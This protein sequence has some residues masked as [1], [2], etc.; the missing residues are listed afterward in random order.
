MR[1]SIQVIRPYLLG[2]VTV[3]LAFA[4][5]SFIQPHISTSPPFIL[6]LVAIMFVAWAWG[7]RPAVWVTL[8]SAIL[9]DY[10][11]I[12]PLQS[13]SLSVA[14]FGSLLFFCVVA[15]TMAYTIERLRTGQREAITLGRQL[16][17][18]HQLSTQLFQEKNVEQTLDSIL[19][20]AIDLLDAD[21]GLLQLYDAPGKTLLLTAQTGFS[22]EFCR[23]FERVSLDFSSCGA[24]FQRRQ[25][26]MIENL[27]TD[28]ELS[29]IASLFS[30]DHVSSAQSTPL[31]RADGHVLGVLTTYSPHLPSE[32]P[33]HLFDLFAQQAARILEAKLSQETL[34][35]NKHALEQQLSIT[36]QRL[37]RTISE[38][39]ISEEQERR[40]LASEL[41]DYLAQM[42]ALGNLKLQLAQRALESS[43]A[44]AQR[45]MKET[46][47]A[48][49]R[50]MVYTRTVM[51]EL[52]PPE[53]RSSGLPAALV[54]LARQMPK[55]GLTVS[56]HMNVESVDLPH[57]QA[58][59]LYKSARELL[60]NVIKHA[61]TDQVTLSLSIDPDET[62]VLSV[63]DH[64]R[65]YDPSAAKPS[66]GGRNFGLASIRERMNVIGG[67]L[68]EDSTIGSGT[69]I[70]LGLPL[71]EAELQRPLRAAS[72]SS[73][74]DRVKSKPV[75]SSE[76]ERLPYENPFG[77]SSQ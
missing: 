51:A 11:L 58:V 26:V 41:H 65:G 37:R 76:Q 13:L 49:Q 69:T 27:A 43:P 62:L 18:L 36:E 7:L 45:Y 59:L 33:L 44:D 21:K 28:P 47:E 72:S 64:G 46:G 56:L 77:D 8:L 75:E 32:K 20:V 6:F 53:L 61:A 54:W 40:T 31:F 34:R 57:D 70:T 38:L 42:L 48:L 39:A 35:Q 24:A 23:R 4:V 74:Q 19:K 29:Q 15:V 2:T 60:I 17:D 71:P 67:W 1:R 68:R 63:E 16:E 14:D 73:A 30:T 10:S 52:I 25:R 9:I 66:G 22:E 55:H 50:S 12:P 3:F 5:K